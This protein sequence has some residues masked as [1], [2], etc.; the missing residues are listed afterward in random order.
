MELRKENISSWQ[1]LERVT[2]GQT[3]MSRIVSSQTS[4]RNR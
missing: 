1:I 3:L 2:D 4:N